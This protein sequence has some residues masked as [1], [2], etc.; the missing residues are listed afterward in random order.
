V[1]AAV[2]SGNRNF[3]GRV[4]P[5]VRANYLASPP[6]VVAYALAGT[7]DIDLVN[8]P[9]GEDQEGNPVC[10][11]E[12]WP[13][14]DEIRMTIAQ[15][16]QPEMFMTKYANVFSGNETWNAIQG[17]GGDLC[18]VRRVNLHPG[19]SILYRPQPEAKPIRAIT[20]ACPGSFRLDH[21]RSHIASRKHCGRQPQEY[22]MA[23]H[24]AARFQLQL[25]EDQAGL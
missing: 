4:H 19:T 17:D 21:D 14:M 23:W 1:A 7:V 8:E 12:I 3:E 13:S 10:L 6:L 25:A 15:A 22:L 5:Y 11:N 24:P 9:I 20:K 18:L 16:I 2:I